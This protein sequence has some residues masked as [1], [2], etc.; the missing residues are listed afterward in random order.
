MREFT[1]ILIITFIS[2]SSF[3]QSKED[4]Q[5][6][7][8]NAVEA[9]KLMDNGEIDRSI[10]LLEE[11][12]K[13]APEDIN[14]PY[15]I[16]YAYY[17]KENYSKSAEYFEKVIGMKGA[18]DQ[19]YQ[20]LGNAYD[21]AGLQSKAIETYNKGLK[22]FPKSGKLYLELGNM[23]RKDLTKALEFY[24]K[25]I[26]V[27]PTFSSNYYWASKI[28]CNSTE[29]LWGMLYGELFMNIE[30]G[31]K[32]TEEISKLLF[33]TYFSEI[34]FPNDTMMTVSFCQTPVINANKKLKM[35]FGLV[36][37][38]SLMVAI[39]E[40]EITLSSLNRI[41]ANFISFYYERNFNKSHPNI[42]FEWHKSLI[43]NGNF[44]CYNY[45]ILM[46]GDLDEFGDWYEK[47]NDKFQEFLNWFSD[48][49]MTIDKK[50]TFHRNDY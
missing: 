44:E 24:E 50:H 7:Y 3:S 34:Q 22:E 17:L 10:Q 16:G 21:M 4:K 37:E 38:P 36:Y 31:S 18:N 23:Q 30:R 47:N 15:E 1:T 28:F 33:D 25:G 2:F 48:N 9:I 27:D 43:D 49:P 39:S 19:S 32:R 45:W 42:L 11:S 41:R 5:K 46:Q 6:A 13:L 12:C 26:E 20:M 29:E 35:P 8:D 14:Y 40:R